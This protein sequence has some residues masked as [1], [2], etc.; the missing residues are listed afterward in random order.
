M[1]LLNESNEKFIKVLRKN[2]SSKLPKK[3]T[4][5]SAGFD[6]YADMEDEIRIEPGDLVKIP[7]GISISLP[8]SSY[9][10]LIFARSG[11]AVNHGITLSNGVGVVDSD[12]RGEI[13]V[14]LCNLSQK[15]YT[16]KPQERIAQMV[17]MPISNLSLL[18]VL[19]L[20]DTVRGENGFG[21]T[22]K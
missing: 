15:P 22:G 3:A 17:V 13:M 7:T 11:L 14:G 9:V 5:G 2:Q 1:S 21:S 18:E 10:A 16:I 12:Y 20:G 8:N 6:L 19:R 4:T